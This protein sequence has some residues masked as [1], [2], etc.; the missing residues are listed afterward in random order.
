M[1]IQTSLNSPFIGSRPVKA[2]SLPT[3]AAS[4]PSD[5]FTLSSGSDFDLKEAVTW[6]GLGAVPALG[7]VSNFVI[8]AVT[9]VAQ[10]KRASNA[11]FSGMLANVVGTATLVTGLIIGNTPTS[12]VG[13]GLLLASGAA[14][15]YSVNQ[16]K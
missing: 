15:A 5:S 1:N 16:N 14:G 9:G 12:L 7:A 6:G 10:Q 3:I 2:S 4:G 13:G 8:G 11:A